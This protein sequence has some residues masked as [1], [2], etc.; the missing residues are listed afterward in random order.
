MKALDILIGLT[1]SIVEE[2]HD[3]IQ[4]IFSDDT[5]MHIFNSYHYD[6]DTLQSVEGEKVVSVNE[7]EDRVEI[8]LKNGTS[9]SIGLKE[10]DYSGPEA[11]VLRR[12]GESPVVWN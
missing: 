4:I 10:E 1:I 11:M 2:I 5:T 8:Q 12:K 7:L 9:I 3:Y 6:G